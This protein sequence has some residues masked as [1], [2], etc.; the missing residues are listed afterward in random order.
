M[1]QRAFSVFQEGAYDCKIPFGKLLVML[2]VMAGLL[3]PANILLKHLSED[4]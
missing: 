1:M 2:T 4:Y 3:K